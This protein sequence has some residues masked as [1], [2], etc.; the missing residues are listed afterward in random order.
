MKKRVVTILSVFF[1]VAT[2]F[3]TS[4]S[5]Q[6]EPTEIRFIV[7]HADCSG[8]GV[9]FEFFV[10]GTSVGVYSPSQSCTCNTDPLV[11]VLNDAE[12][13]NLIG[14]LGC[15]NLEL[16]L[17]DPGYSLAFGYA[18]A[19]IDR[20]LSGTE[21]YCIYNASGSSGCEDRELCNAYDMPGTSSYENDVPDSD[22]D[23]IPDCTD[24]DIDGDGIENEI[25]N[26]RTQPNTTQVD[27]DADGVG[28]VCDNC[29]SIVNPDQSNNDTDDLGDACDNCPD[30]DNGDQAD[31]DDD[32]EGDFCEASADD[33]DEDYDGIC[34]GTDNCTLYPNPGQEDTDGDGI[35]NACEARAICVPWNPANP[36]TPHST[37]S[38]AQTT[39]KGI[40]RNA[41]EFRW[42]FGDGNGTA[43]TAIS[44]TYNLGVSHTYTGAL[45]QL[46][47]ATLYVRDANGQVSQDEYLIEIQESTD[48]SIRAHLDVRINMA[49]DEGLWWLHTNMIRDTYPDGSPGYEQKYGYW[50]PGYYPLG[51]TS[52]AVDAF[53]LHGSKAHLDFDND[54]Y[55]ETVQRGLNYILYNTY[56]FN[57]DEEPAGNP[58][59]N[60]NGIGLVSNQSSSATDSR[61]T[62]LGGIAMLTLASSGAPNRLAKCGG[63][64]VYGR[65]MSEIIQDM[66]DFW[67][68]GQ[69]D[70]GNG[71]GGWRYYANYSD[72]DMSTA[73]WPPLAM[74]AA[75]NNMGSVVPQFVRDELALFLDYVQS[76]DMDDDNGGFGYDT[77]DLWNNITKASAGIICHEFIGTPLTD[78]RV[79]SAIGF[80]Y[81]HW[82]DTGTSWDHTKLHGNS[83]GM[84][85][86]MKAFRIPEPDILRVTEY[87]YN[88]GQQTDSSFDWYYTPT[89]QQE[90]G[91]A[92]YNVQTQQA[93][94]SWDDNVGSNQLY[95][96]FATGWR[97]LILLKGVTVIP[98]EAVIC[99]CDEQ[100]YNL[101]QTINLDG[102][103]SYHQDRN[104]RIVNYSWDLG[105]DGN[106]D[107]SGPEA[108]ILGGFSTAG[109]YPVC[110]TVTDDNPEDPQTAVAEC[111][112]F[113]HPP[114]HCPH[115]FAGGPYL[116]WVNVP[117]QFNAG[118]SWDPDN[119]IASYEWDLDNDGLFGAED[120]DCFGQGSDAV[121]LS[122]E[123]TWNV[124]YSGV[125]GLRITDAEGEYEVCS[126]VDYSRVDVGNHAPVADPGDPYTA[127]INSCITLDG[128]YSYDID[129]GDEIT[130]SWDID[131][132]GG[133]GDCVE[134]ECEFC[135]EDEVGTVHDV[136]LRVDDTFG[137]YAISCTTVE[138]VE[139]LPPEAVC[140][141]VTLEADASCVACGTI[142]NGSSDPDGPPWEITLEP[143]CPY[144]LGETPV[145]LTITD[146]NG[147]TDSCGATV[148]VVDNSAPQIECPPDITLEC[149]TDTG[150]DA[151]GFAVVND[152]CGVSETNYADASI[153]GPGNTGAII[154][155]WNGIDNSG[156]TSSC[157][158]YIEVVDTLPPQL[159]CSVETPSL[160]PPDHGMVDV[161]LDLIT[162]DACD[163]ELS[164]TV[165]VTS[166]EATATEPGSGGEIHS[167]DAEVTCNSAGDC[168]VQLR[169]ERSGD[170]DGRVYVITTTATD[171]S[172]N[173]SS[174]SC[175][176]VVDHDQG[177]DGAA[178]DSGQNY[179]ATEVN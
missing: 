151:T 129:P 34:D 26:C 118:A 124:P 165:S 122:P 128:T 139:A 68:W 1:A 42:D 152:N 101:N 169:A 103:C 74:M 167:P 52:V 18:R 41:T 119:E 145:T 38:G 95:D 179:Y 112:V 77:P 37:Y 46:F 138:V 174:A 106:P 123:W 17:D 147:F 132:D 82:D 32:G 55:V 75:E 24:P 125:I 64:Y 39:L 6:D 84:Y 135:V 71:R 79:E 61:Q 43:W 89:G 127:S 110:L 102:S 162:S 177:K 76:T 47:I 117:L 142:D 109:Y 56:A 44:D 178:I 8:G 21:T 72:S 141:N 67:A 173:A 114:P 100:E 73:Q 96:A 9:A 175:T 78:P 160:W 153:P 91:L 131:N 154:R 150:P 48:L 31:C 59:A 70:S 133:F 158:Q 105:C 51:S 171:A 35:G 15:T 121:G 93:D 134:A 4:V 90:L 87:D 143:E 49:I 157:E 86:T 25:D 168:V 164:I 144:S 97:V 10:N 140:Q 107:V 104:R 161:G 99:D 5:A 60:G 53:Q 69:V 155:I 13:L 2:L 111:S 63:D 85:G 65:T 58:D 80:I 20:P 27:R 163:T 3:A 176:V 148:T 166:D 50:D 126:D 116:G 54:P 94:G 36:S 62:Y 28:D 92:T 159:S 136:C 29:P 156:N 81:R 33:Q 11:V 149:P 172:D 83:Y 170:N 146:P 30:M 98:P 113:V 115:A 88:A 7:G 57:I 22:G 12:T 108:T 120:D 45:R 16:F 40:A 14:A 19:E 66:V 137:E 130:F 23:G